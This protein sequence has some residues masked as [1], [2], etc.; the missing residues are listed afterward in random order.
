MLFH[1]NHQHHALGKTYEAGTTIF[2]QKD[3]AD[4][5]YLILQGAVEMATEQPDSGWVSI[6]RLQKDDMFGTTS[7]FA[8]SSRI[9]T[10]RTL[11]ETRLLTIDQNGFFQRVSDD[12]ALAAQI[13]RN[14]ANYSHRL[15]DKII[16]LQTAKID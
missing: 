5:F 4:C 10:A 6:D 11:V 3:P 16:E 7:F 9:L 14:M 8:Q 15:I 1:S 13:L 12:P 2:R